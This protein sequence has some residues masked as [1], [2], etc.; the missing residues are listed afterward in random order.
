MTT[1]TY[2]DDGERIVLPTRLDER[3]AARRWGRG[4]LRLAR[5]RP[6][7]AVGFVI[8]LTLLT[9]AL[10]APVLAPYDV[11]ESHPRARLQQPSRT[12]LMGTDRFGRD[13]FS[14]VLFG[15]R[16]D[17]GIAVL[18]VALGIAAG[19]VIGLVT[20]YFAGGF[21]DQ[22]LQRLIDIQMT[23]PGLVLAITII[24]GVGKGYASVVVV[25]AFLL[26]PATARVLRGAALAERGRQYVEAGR[27]IGCT[28]L[29]LIFRHILPNIAAPLL[30]L[31]S[32]AMGSALLISG[33][34]SFLGYGPP[35]PAPTLGGLLVGDNRAVLKSAPWLSI[36]PG[37][38]LALAVFSVNMLGDALRDELDPRLRG[39]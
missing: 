13:T 20:G 27:A 12:Y 23:V 38:V 8:L 37:L 21:V 25:I 11:A 29:R 2:P 9:G 15:M 6:L 19:T 22:L 7:G 34:L 28:D 4:A 1:R 32:V 16:T 18:S 31:M 24:T 35:P 14:R 3:A 10:L 17:F 30:I 5:K 33:G 39:R 36:F 26:I